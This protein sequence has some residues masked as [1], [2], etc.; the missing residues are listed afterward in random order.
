MTWHDDWDS[1]QGRR[2]DE[3]RFQR[4]MSEAGS[5]ARAWA[6]R[7][8]EGAVLDPRPTLDQRAGWLIA[9]LAP[10]RRATPHPAL[11]DDEG[12]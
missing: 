1:E 11:D 12:G 3:Q 8:L 5:A 2:E 9:A 4:A 10:S 7:F 6:I